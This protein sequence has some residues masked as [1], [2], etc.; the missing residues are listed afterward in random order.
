MNG[1][2][3]KN[4][5]VISLIELW[6]GYEFLVSGW[7]KLVLSKSFTSGLSGYLKAMI[8]GQTGWYSNLINQSILPHAPVFGYLIEWAEVIAGIILIVAPLFLMPRIK[9][10]ILVHKTFSILSILALVSIFVMSLN[11][12]LILKWPSPLPGQGNPYTPGVSFDFF[13]AAMS[14]VLIWWN[15]VGMKSISREPT[16]KTVHSL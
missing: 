7:N 12:Y 10:N 8:G 11:F 9:D 4:V 5:I 14:L 6:L 13:I 3:Q 1:A 15:V 16:E 2:M